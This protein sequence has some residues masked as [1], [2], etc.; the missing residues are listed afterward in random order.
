MS[1]IPRIGTSFVDLVAIYAHPTA[2]A[3]TLKQ[4]QQKPPVP[5]FCLIFTVKTSFPNIFWML[6]KKWKN[7]SRNSTKKNFFNPFTRGGK[8]KPER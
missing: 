7:F 5:L 1:E 2:T 3:T 8:V 6:A 4:W